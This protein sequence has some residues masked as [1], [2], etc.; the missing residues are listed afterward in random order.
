MQFQKYYL[1]LNNFFHLAT[2]KSTGSVKDI[3]QLYGISE[4]TVKRMIKDVEFIKNVK[5]KFCRFETS[6][7]I[8]HKASNEK[9]TSN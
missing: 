6:Y 2:T 3:G 9:T 4:S 5:L 1:Q 8:T 7:I